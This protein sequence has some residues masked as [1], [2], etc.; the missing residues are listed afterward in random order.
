MSADTVLENFANYTR[1]L[2]LAGNYQ[3]DFAVLFTWLSL[4]SPQG[5]PGSVCGQKPVSVVEIDSS[6]NQTRAVQE[7]AVEIARSLGIRHTSRQNGVPEKFEDFVSNSGLVKLNSRSG[8]R[9]IDNWK[10]IV[11]KGIFPCLLNKPSAFLNQLECGNGFVE[12]AEE[13]DCGPVEQCQNQCCDAHTCQLRWTTSCANG[14]C[15]D[16]MACQPHSVKTLCREAASECDMPEYCDGESNSCPQDLYKRNADLCN[17]GKA[18][19]YNGTCP[20]RDDQC[21]LLWGQTAHSADQC[22]G[23]NSEAAS[24]GNMFCG[25][26][27]CDHA[28]DGGNIFWRTDE[29]VIWHGTDK[30]C[31]QTVTFESEHATIDP[32]LVPDG[33]KCGDEKICLRQ[34]CVPID[35]IR[36]AHAAPEC[37]NNCYGYGVCDNNGR[38][39]CYPGY[40]PP[41]CTRPAKS[42]SH[43]GNTISGF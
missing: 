31:C 34:K 29:H 20:S 25:R 40:E 24:L 17:T 43:Q 10:K 41:S 6:L 36:A 1:R 32:G 7:T 3:H 27:H 21:K 14:E 30:V 5:F 18:Y 15:C 33:S 4:S 35:E 13:C 26:L 16:L 12:D 42:V 38:C 2:S 19:C 28:S 22:Y 9:K 37:P 8:S 23:L 39:H 11:R